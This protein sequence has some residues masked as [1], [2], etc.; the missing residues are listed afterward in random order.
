[1]AATL[2]VAHP[3]SEEFGRALG[4][5]RSKLAFVRVEVAAGSVVCS[6]VL[7]EL[8]PLRAQVVDRVMHRLEESLRLLKVPSSTFEIM[9]D[10]L[11]GKRRYLLDFIADL[12]E[13]GSIDH[14]LRQYVHIA[15]RV[16]ESA[17]SAYC[18]AL[19]TW[20]AI[21]RAP[22][23]SF[24]LTSIAR[25]TTSIF[26]AIF[27]ETLFGPG[28]VADLAERT[29][30]QKGRE[31]G[32]GA[33]G[34]LGRVGSRRERVEAVLRRWTEALR[35]ARQPGLTLADILMRQRNSHPTVE[36]VCRNATLFYLDFLERE[37]RFLTGTFGEGSATFL[38]NVFRDCEH[39]PL[40]LIQAKVGQALE[41]HDDLTGILICLL[42]NRVHRSKIV[43]EET[44]DIRITF[45]VHVEKV[46]QTR[47][48]A[49]FDDSVEKL[50]ALP[51]A[52]LKAGL[53]EVYYS[54]LVAM[55]T[56]LVTGMLLVIIRATK[57]VSA[58]DIFD[59]IQ[60]RLLSFVKQLVKTIELVGHSFADQ[61][62]RLRSHLRRTA[63]VLTVLEVPVDYVIDGDVAGQLKEPVKAL[64]SHACEEYGACVVRKSM[65]EL[66][67][68]QEAV[69]AHQYDEAKVE[70]TRF[71][72]KLNF[73]IQSMADSYSFLRDESN[74]S[75]SYR[76]AAIEAA[77]KDLVEKNDHVARLVQ[78]RMPADSHFVVT[79][80][81]LV[82]V[83]NKYR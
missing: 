73:K 52:S 45:L 34:A 83:A 17:I 5:L 58:E 71:R 82:L 64:F 14:V 66:F 44:H 20:A 28:E 18:D 40:V 72:D 27:T 80:G 2:R 33:A 19:A 8:E 1:M 43:E 42:L 51:A 13:D 56:D 54:K 31:E 61:S 53:G 26:S 7:D 38:K 4:E 11:L 65:G 70:L 12:A 50:G 36:E 35:A 6:E 59:T 29:G 55:L 75:R 41:H 37:R 49:E 48:L 30:I 23:S 60:R 69:E 15:S 57:D 3:H 21:E 76:R 46:L 47:L 77:L 9:R 22:G 62:S 67:K 10:T 81:E 25:G 32:D 78:E 24:D 68:A 16:A 63:V 79:K 39:S 74:I